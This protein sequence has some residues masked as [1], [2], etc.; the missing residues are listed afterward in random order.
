MRRHHL[1]QNPKRNATQR[2]GAGDTFGVASFRGRSL[3][4]SAAA[5]HSFID[6]LRPAM[7]TSFRRRRPT[8]AA[9][10]VGSAAV[11]V[12]EKGASES[13][14][15][16]PSI[17]RLPGTKNW[18][19]G[20]TL[21][22]TGLREI[23]AILGGGQPLGTAILVEEDRLSFDLGM[24]LARYW[25]AEAVAQGQTL[26]LP[27]TKKDC[28][29]DEEADDDLDGDEDVVL[30]SG[31][32]SS[33]SEL[34]NY[35]NTIPRDLHLDKYRS[36]V[37]KAMGASN[38]DA[39][40]DKET[41][42]ASIQEGDEEED[43]DEF[44]DFGE[45]KE[46][47]KNNDDGLQIAWQYRESVQKERLGHHSSSSSAKTTT[48]RAPPSGD[49]HLRMRDVYCHSYDLAGSMKA[50]HDAAKFMEKIDTFECACR[51]CGKGQCGEMQQCGFDLFRS[52]LKRVQHHL[53]QSG[54]VG[55]TSGN[56]VRLLL[57][58]APPAATAIAL[59]LLLSY[60][61][62]NSL[63]FAV[64]ITVRPW[65]QSTTGS[66]ISLRRNCDAV[67]AMDGFASFR[68]PPPPEF[69]ELAGIMTLRKIASMGA[70][71]FANATA[72][73]RPPS[74]RY[75]LKRDRRKLH[76][77]LLH[78]PPEEESAG[79]SST[80]GVRSGGGRPK[81]SSTTRTGGCSGGGSVSKLDF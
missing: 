11:G 4:C 60:G 25:G 7:S 1:P 35:V 40:T 50:Q 64:M 24:C 13:L 80:S 15:A 29:W 44:D 70:G 10:A 45:S 14:P 28:D 48:S 73:R 52:L 59:P 67:L 36:R 6:I 22:S 77:R 30:S 58:D 72:G 49:D 12:G 51:R 42:I 31:G 34:D 61:R 54:T 3:C 37:G 78:L 38:A 26:L 9:A 39:D 8:P 23:D 2:A 74:D 53:S 47:E 21:L 71:H 68:D 43:D 18:T 62:A 75:G 63:A 20:L 56:V 5:A 16:A 33:P 27:A 65:N 41:P 46:G 17:A 81:E 66:L 76:V 57:L 79:G 32:G 19:G 55:S 69:R